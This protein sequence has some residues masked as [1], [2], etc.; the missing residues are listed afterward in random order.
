MYFD[1]S[2]SCLRG[3]GVDRQKKS[4][5]APVQHK[6]RTKRLRV[7][8]Q[9][10]VQYFD[11]SSGD[12]FEHDAI[13]SYAIGRLERILSCALWQGAT[14]IVPTPHTLNLK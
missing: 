13:A 6:G 9:L 12:Y 1:Y 14:V 10:G 7:K 3:S 4:I 2:V 11:N 8:I 5:V